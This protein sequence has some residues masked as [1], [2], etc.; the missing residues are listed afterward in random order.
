MAREGDRTIA[1]HA[2]LS[3]SR[4]SGWGRWWRVSITRDLS[5]EPG[6][7]DDIQQ[8]TASRGTEVA[9]VL[10]GDAIR[11]GGL[12]LGQATEVVLQFLYV[13]LQAAGAALVC[14]GLAASGSELGDLSL[15]RTVQLGLPHLP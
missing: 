7:V 10:V 14:A 2:L 9:E 15:L 4:P 12:L 1:G 8:S 13:E 6:G 5:L 11:T 3:P